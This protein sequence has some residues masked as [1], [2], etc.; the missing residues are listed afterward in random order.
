VFNHGQAM[1]DKQLRKPE[2]LLQI[3]QQVDNLRLN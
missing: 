2:L 1:G 3:R